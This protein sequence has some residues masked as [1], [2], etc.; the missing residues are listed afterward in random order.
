M[1]TCYRR[2]LGVTAPQGKT[3]KRARRMARSSAVFAA[4]GFALSLPGVAYA[5]VAR[6]AIA[7]EVTVTFT[8]S[9]LVVSRGSFEAGPAT[10]VVVN[11]GQKPHV[12][13]I[14][15]P[16]IKNI[17]TRKLAT[18]K[19]ATLTLTLRTGAYMLTDPIGRSNPHWIVVS[20]VSVV[21]ANGNG[22][23][24]ASSQFTDPGMN[25]D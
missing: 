24:G 20:P 11:K 16:G 1:S 15:G 21:H 12:L 25:C 6:H 4:F 9:K 2:T 18:G 14:I 10:F 3:M 5:G 7:A 22:T 17:R 13:A 23:A 19:S 8:D